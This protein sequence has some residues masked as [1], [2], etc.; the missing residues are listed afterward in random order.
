[1]GRTAR[2][3]RMFVA[4]S[5]PAEALADLDTFLEPRR[6]HAPFRWADVEQLHL[7]LAF[8][9][10]VPDHALDDLVDGLEQAAARRTP[11]PVRLAG[12]GAFPDP[13]HAKVLYAGLDLDPDAG[14]ELD[15]LA[16]GARTAAARAGVAVDGRRFRPHL[17]L[18]RLGQPAGVDDW[19][20]LLD[21]YAGPTW[22]VDRISLLASHLGEG[23]RGR[24]RYEVVE[25]LALG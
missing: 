21:A 8:C 14:T 24:P 13:A 22:T 6:E 12:G 16:T 11:F 20:K 23:R 10:S 3:E 15:R 19:V 4:V 1:M 5:P 17:T 7:T 25:E 9:E 2:G 18:A